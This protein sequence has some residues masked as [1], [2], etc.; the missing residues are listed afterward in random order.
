MGRYLD[1]IRNAS[2]TEK[3]KTPT[4]DAMTMAQLEGMADEG[5]PAGGRGPRGPA[6]P[7]DFQPFFALADA[8]A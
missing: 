3:A 2:D 6:R 4:Y 8:A 5:I 7:Q 1:L